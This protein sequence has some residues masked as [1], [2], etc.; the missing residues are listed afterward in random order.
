MSDKEIET[1]RRGW[2]RSGRVGVCKIEKQIERDR[3]RE[4]A[5]EIE[6]EKDQNSTLLIEYVTLGHHQRLLRC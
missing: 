4:I 2:G 5:R 6:I 3:G 1:Q